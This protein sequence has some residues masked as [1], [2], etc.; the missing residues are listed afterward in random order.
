ML[1]GALAAV[2]PAAALAGCATTQQE[3]ARLQLNAARIRASEQPT[4]VRAP[5]NAVEVTRVAR[6]VTGGR[7]AFV[8]QVRNAARRPVSDLPIS[9]GVRVRGKRPIYLNRQSEAELSYFDAH[10]PLVAAGGTLTWV[11]TTDR[12]LPAHARPFAVVGGTPSNPAPRSHPLPVI[13]ASAVAPVTTASGAAGTSPVAISLRNL[14]AV[15]QYQLQVYAVAERDGRF[16]AAGSF[17]V[18][19][20]GSNASS[21]L[22]LP[23][24][25]HIN[26]ARLQIEAAPTIF[27]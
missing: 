19:H 12:R 21:R 2:A 1:R 20:L 10:L 9:V 5:G 27:Q 22:R 25:G 6:I 23:I 17:T 4:E 13:R 24:L 15:P 11:Y 14:S 26:H 16:V 3:A 18:P 8:V 7:S